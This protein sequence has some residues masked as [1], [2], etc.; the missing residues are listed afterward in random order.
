[1]LPRWAPI[2]HWIG[3]VTGLQLLV[4][5]CPCVCVE[6]LPFVSFYIKLPD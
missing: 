2:L 6:M 5:I 4:M 3:E 1:M